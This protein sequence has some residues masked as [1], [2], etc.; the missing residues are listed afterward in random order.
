MK[1]FDGEP[2]DYTLAHTPLG[3]WRLHLGLG[4]HSNIDNKVIAKIMNKGWRPVRVKLVE[5]PESDEGDS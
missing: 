1:L 3:A 5:V 4:V 2:D